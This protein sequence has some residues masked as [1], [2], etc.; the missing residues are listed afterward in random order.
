MGSILGIKTM[1][2]ILKNDYASTKSVL[3]D[4]LEE[5]ERS[6]DPLDELAQAM[7]FDYN[8]GEVELNLWL[9]SKE[10]ASIPY[11]MKIKLFN[12]FR[13]AASTKELSEIRNLRCRR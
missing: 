12:Y 3:L 1:N 7:L 9:T 11:P 13:Y 6:P 2:E 8:V 4:A 10:F 5:L